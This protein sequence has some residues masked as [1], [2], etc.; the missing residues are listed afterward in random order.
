VIE[1]YTYD[2]LPDPPVRAVVAEWLRFH[3]VDPHDVPAPGWIERDPYSRAV[4]ALAMPP[5][6]RRR[7]SIDGE[8]TVIAA[9]DGTARCVVESRSEGEPLPWPVTTDEWFAAGGHSIDTYPLDLAEW[10]RSD[11]PP[12]RPT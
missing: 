1:R 6:E 2:R 10:W 11:D 8:E 7:I 4:R 5:W 12:V 9:R 3:G